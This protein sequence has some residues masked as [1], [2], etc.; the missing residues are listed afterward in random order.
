MAVVVNDVGVRTRVDKRVLDRKL[1]FV[2]AIGFP[3]I[4]LAGFGRT[5]YLK[6]FFDVPPL[7]SSLVHVHGLLMTAWVALFVTQVSLIS[8]RRVRVHQRLGYAGIG[9]AVLILAVGFVVAVRAAKFGA[10]SSPPGIPRLAFLLVPLTDLVMFAV[11]FGAAVYFRKRP[12]NHKRLMLLTAV[13]FLPPA[14]ARIQIAS[15][16]ALGPLWFFGFPTV[17]ALACV[18]WDTWRNERLNTIFLAGTILLIVSYVG[19]LILM[20][21]TTWMSVATW[22]TSFV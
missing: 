16:Q 13:N 9:L 4:V 6:G 14:V 17:L 12:A 7:A 18:G 22:L 1:F 10:F 5:Y 20:G 3:L 11:L 2:S 8:T 15:L 19:R 21:T